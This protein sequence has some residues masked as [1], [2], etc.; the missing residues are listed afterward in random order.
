MDALLRI[1]RATGQ[2][3]SPRQA[4]SSRRI[5]RARRRGGRKL[6]STIVRRPIGDAA[7]GNREAAMSGAD[8][9]EVAV[10]SRQEDLAADSRIIFAEHMP[11]VEP[12]S[13]DEAHLDQD[14]KERSAGTRRRVGAPVESKRGDPPQ[15][16]RR[17]LTISFWR[18]RLRP[19]R[20]N[21]QYVITPEMGP[22]FVEALPV[23]KFHGIGPTSAKMNSLGHYTDLDMRNRSPDFLQANFGK[24][25]VYYFWNSRADNREVRRNR[26]R[27]SVGAENTFSI[28]TLRQIL[29]LPTWQRR[30][31]PSSYPGQSTSRQ[32]KADRSNNGDDGSRMRAWQWTTACSVAAL[33][34]EAGLHSPN[35]EQR[36]RRDANAL[37]HRCEQRSLRPLQSPHPRD[38]RRR[39]PLDQELI[40]RWA[41]AAPAATA[42]CVTA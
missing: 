35:G 30:P 14:R 21:G 28:R 16:F 42:A 41:E 24:A 32:R 4:S 9:R 25:G 3:G 15:R 27:K 17:H 23:G 18:T 22:A 10:Q 11:I 38:D 2:S 19:H 33:A 36:P 7:I 37:H 8:L 6:R 5:L 39:A 13:L 31:A 1:R 34:S 20:P 40:E 26:I 29:L 12:L